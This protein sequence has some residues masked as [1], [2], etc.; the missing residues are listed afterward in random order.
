M[1]SQVILLPR[2]AL[3][4]IRIT[5]LPLYVRCTYTQVEGVKLLQKTQFPGKRF[6]SFSKSILNMSMPLGISESS[7]WEKLHDGQVV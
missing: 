6:Q 2:V 7:T 5:E 1:H 3:C 4:I